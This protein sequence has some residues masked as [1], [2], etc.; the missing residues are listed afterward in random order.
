MIPMD[1]KSRST[2]SPILPDRTLRFVIS[3]LVFVALALPA[4]AMDRL[5]RD[6]FDVIAPPDRVHGGR[7]D[8][9]IYQPACRIGPTQQAR[10]RIV[11]VAAQEWG[12]FG[13][14][15]IDAATVETRAL[16]DGLVP[17]AANPVLS[18]PRI[19]RRAD[20][21]GTF[22]DDPSLDTTI[23]GY[24]SATPDG[25]ADIIAK[26][27]A[28]WRGPGG[29]AVNWVEPWS[30]AFVSWVMCEAGLG[31][32]KQFQRS[33][34]HRTYIDQAIHA[35]DGE[36]PDAAYEA[37]DVGEL[38]IEP[39]DLLCNSRGGVDY[40]SVADRRKDLGGYV[41]AHC[42]IVV[43]SEPTR[44]LV[45]GGNVLQSV[46]LTILPLSGEGSAYPRPIDDSTIS[47]ARTVFAHL[48]L[49]ADAIE[50]NA[51]DHTPTI[52]ALAAH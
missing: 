18:A 24:W 31:E 8:M 48:K 9:E 35:R 45:I 1:I 44:V 39:G 19:M 15:T 10:R 3:A 38:P 42:D 40:R 29:D 52:R 32:L 6:V 13:F 28:A 34:A 21:L 27:N 43:K 17:D 2:T 23:G 37:H 30:A 12:Y 20:R 4:Q 11:D 33:I 47:G 46:S 22:E 51:L 5:P 41:P 50:T 14:Q 16:P 49:R 25:G 36:A 26:Q 7:G